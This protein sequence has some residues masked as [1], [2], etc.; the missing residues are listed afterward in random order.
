MV[1]SQLS[2]SSQD[3]LKVHEMKQNIF[4]LT[5][6]ST[7]KRISRRITKIYFYKIFVTIP[8][9]LVKKVTLNDFIK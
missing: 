7:I 1:N 9:L 2:F 5:I 4:S 3:K 6:A 8:Q